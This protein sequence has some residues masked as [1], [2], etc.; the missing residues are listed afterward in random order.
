MQVHACVFPV[1]FDGFYSA[2]QQHIEIFHNPR[3]T[4]AEK[5]GAGFYFTTHHPH[6]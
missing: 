3:H 2:H 1:A 4:W 5:Q 6:R